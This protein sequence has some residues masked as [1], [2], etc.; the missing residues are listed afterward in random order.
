MSRIRLVENSTYYRLQICIAMLADR[1]CIVQDTLATAAHG[2]A[3]P[4]FKR[5]SYNWQNKA[6][7]G[8]RISSQSTT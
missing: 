8:V 3:A 6:I 5:T 4:G 1:R 2:V 7:E